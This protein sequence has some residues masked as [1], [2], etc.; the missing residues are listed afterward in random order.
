MNDDPKLRMPELQQQ[1]IDT[2][3][4]SHA[5]GMRDGESEMLYEMSN[6]IDPNGP[7]LTFEEIVA[8]AK[9]GYDS[10]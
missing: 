7:I 4:D 5:W 3:N 10:E 1:L 2:F 8:L 9:K 6:L